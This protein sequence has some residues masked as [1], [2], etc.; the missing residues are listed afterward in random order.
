MALDTTTTPTCAALTFDA[1][2]LKAAL[3]MAGHVIEKR[4]GIPI[5]QTVKAIAWPGNLALVATDLDMRLT[6]KIPADTTDH[7]QAVLWPAPLAAAVAKVKGKAA[8]MFDGP[9]MVFEAGGATIEAGDNL[10]ADD[11]PDMSPVLYQGR[12]ELP[13]SVLLAALCAVAP[14]ISTEETRYYL[15]GVFIHGH[16]KPGADG[17]TLRLV[18]T[19]GHRL[20]LYDLPD[21]WNAPGMILPHKA[22]NVLAKLLKGAGDALVQI[23]T[24]ASGAERLHFEGPGWSLETKAIDGTFP[25]Y[26]RVLPQSPAVAQYMLTQGEIPTIPK[27]AR[28]CAVAL[29][30]GEGL[31]TWAT[32]QAASVASRAIL[33]EGTGTIG[34]DARYLADFAK[35]A[36]GG[37]IT[38][39][40]IGA[41]DPARIK[42]ADARFLGV[43][44]PM[45]V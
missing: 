23:S 34:F 5:L 30:A 19:D 45:R 18:A 1:P 14:C 11:F 9:A 27:G 35:A 12:A 2:A 4:A 8:L 20:G 43:L 21:A 44:M 24:T 37:E 41:G 3:A 25:D 31:M 36:P 40:A 39:D 7:G 22:A 13:A 15:R 28:T 6:L 29:D 26:T 16:Q 33:A 38:I 42:N 32:D 17:P 10:P